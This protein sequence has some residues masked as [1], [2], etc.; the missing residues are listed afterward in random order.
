MN[1]IKTMLYPNFPA[2][3]RKLFIPCFVK[4]QWWK[5]ALVYL[6]SVI[7]SPFRRWILEV[8]FTSCTEKGG[9]HTFMWTVPFFFLLTVVLSVLMELFVSCL[10][11]L[12]I[13]KHGGEGWGEHLSN[14]TS[15][16][17]LLVLDYWELIAHELKPFKVNV[18]KW[19]WY[20]SHIITV[21]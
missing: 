19:A 1:I 6:A 7:V 3:S 15:Q 8:S 21:R 20:N 2:F 12:L 9:L 18:N 4:R 10:A 13:N 11:F 14:C 5:V 16:L 17:N